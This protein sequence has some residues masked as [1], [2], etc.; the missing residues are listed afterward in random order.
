MDSQGNIS[1]LKEDGHQ[2]VFTK[3]ERKALFA[4]LRYVN[5]N[6]LYEQLQNE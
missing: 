6:A 1:I 5:V 2:I 4:V 3:K